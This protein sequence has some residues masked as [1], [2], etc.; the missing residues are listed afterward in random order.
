[1]RAIKFRGKINDQWWYV[2]ATDEPDMG[3]W[4][5]F[6]A[7]V[8]RKTIGQFTGLKDKDGR[9]I[10]EGDVVKGIGY[11]TDMEFGLFTA[12]ELGIVDGYEWEEVS[13]AMAWFINEE[14]ANQGLVIGN[15]YE[16]PELLEKRP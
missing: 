4:E 2:S 13:K 16:N 10:Y 14:E 9:D 8:D 3:E 5:Q 11:Q 6:W 1:M 15:I 7:I 12:G